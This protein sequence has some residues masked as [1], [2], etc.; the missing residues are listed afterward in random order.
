MSII[1]WYR[2][3]GNK[4]ILLPSA[5]GFEY[6]KNHPFIF[7]DDDGLKRPLSKSTEKLAGIDVT[8]YV[9]EFTGDILHSACDASIVYNTFIIRVFTSAGSN[10]YLKIP[11]SVANPNYTAVTI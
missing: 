2:F 9:M 1:K 11:Y 5:E 10:S 4:L 7:T 6:V 3:E 8:S